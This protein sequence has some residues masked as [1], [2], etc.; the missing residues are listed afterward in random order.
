MYENSQIDN[1]ST[2]NELKNYLYLFWSW[3]WLIVLFALLFGGVAYY[4]SSQTTPVY[5]TSTRLLVSDPPAIQS[6][7][8][9]GIVNGS[10]LTGTYAKMLVDRPVL[11]GVIEQLNLSM[12]SDELKPL[13]SVDIISGTQLLSITVQNTNPIQAADIANTIADVFT[14]RI[15]DLQ[16]QR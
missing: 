3:S 12:T 11:Q 9:S 15:R 7:N 6:L 10:S 16:A 14:Q 1:S 8:Y 5:E 13:I 4:V 2:I